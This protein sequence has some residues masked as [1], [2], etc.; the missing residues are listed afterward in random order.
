MVL[1][2]VRCSQPHT[3]LAWENL[4]GIRINCSGTLQSVM[5]NTLRKNRPELSQL[6]VAL[7]SRA[8]KNDTIHNSIQNSMSNV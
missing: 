2:E 4:Q 1:L 5:S 8:R 6:R 3:L 7:K